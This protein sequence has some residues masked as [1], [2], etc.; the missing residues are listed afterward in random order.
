MVVELRGLQ[1]SKKCT[2]IKP[3]MCRLQQVSEAHSQDPELRE[4]HLIG[5]GGGLMQSGDGMCAA[6]DAG[7]ALLTMAALTFRVWVRR[8]AVSMKGSE[9]MRPGEDSL[10]CRAV[11]LVDASAHPGVITC[12]HTENSTEHVVCERKGGKGMGAA[13]RYWCSG[14]Q[15]RWQWIGRCTRGNNRARPHKGAA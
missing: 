9:G 2:V 15:G 10:S 12:A 4:P 7:L 5:E 3:G 14:K 6:G 11:T 8:L 13:R 1:R